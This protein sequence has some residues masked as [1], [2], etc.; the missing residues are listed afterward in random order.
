LACGISR[1]KRAFDLGVAPKISSAFCKCV[2]KS[3]WYET[4][5]WL[6][7]RATKSYK[8]VTGLCLD[9]QR[10]KNPLDKIALEL[11]VHRIDTEFF[12]EIWTVNAGVFSGCTEFFSG[13]ILLPDF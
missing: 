3:P 9:M 12:S 7:D 4:S 2:L 8:G 1:Q 5:S 11:Q 6:Y 10:G 13:L